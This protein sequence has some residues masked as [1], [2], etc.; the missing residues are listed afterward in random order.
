MADR[1]FAADLWLVGGGSRSC[2]LRL[3]WEEGFAGSSTIAA[4]AGDGSLFPRW[5]GPPP[6]EGPAGPVDLAVSAGCEGASRVR[7]RRD[8]SRILG[9]FADI[10]RRSSVKTAPEVEDTERRDAALTKWGVIVQRAGIHCSLGEYML[11]AKDE[12]KV[13]QL[14]KD[15]FEEKAT[16]TLEKRGSAM[17]AYIRWCDASRCEPFP[18]AAELAYEYVC[19]MRAEGA[20]AT[21]ATSFVEALGFA[22]G[23]VGLVSATMALECRLLKGAAV[24]LFRTKRPERKAALLS[25]EHVL[26]LENAIVSADLRWEDRVFAGFCCLCLHVRSRWTAAA[27]LRTEPTL[28]ISDDEVYGFIEIQLLDHKTGNAK[29]K[30]R[31]LLPLAGLA[32]GLSGKPWAEAWVELR[33][34]HGLTLAGEGCLMPCPKTGGGFTSAR[35]SSCD[36][37][38]WLRELLNKLCGK[39]ERRTSVHTV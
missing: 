18:I 29:K 17:L 9:A 11:N 28:D 16:G 21:R 39:L 8:P 25:K 6:P 24:S 14:L 5:A 27:S 13:S 26:A 3:P 23:T 30:R 33:G 20:P 36:G 37:A 22:R 19:F 2:G 10:A 31:K 12:A 15:S 38:V 7:T 35:L 32:H 4:L 1:A 34:E